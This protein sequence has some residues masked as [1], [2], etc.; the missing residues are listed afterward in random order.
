MADFIVAKKMS[1]I[2]LTGGRVFFVPVGTQ[3]EKYHE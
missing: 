3:P 2:A 1:A